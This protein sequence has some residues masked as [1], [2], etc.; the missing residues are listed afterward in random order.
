MEEMCLFEFIYCVGKLIRFGT[1]GFSFGE[2]E[3]ASLCCIR[4]SNLLMSF[5]GDMIEGWLKN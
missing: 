4:L 3:Y 1:S 2:L 5:T